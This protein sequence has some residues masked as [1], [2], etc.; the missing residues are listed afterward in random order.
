MSPLR[1]RILAA[2]LR[3]FDVLVLSGAFLLSLWVSSARETGMPVGE[4]LSVR[5]RAGNFILLAAL[6]WL[7]H[8]LFTAFGLY[9]SRRLASRTGEVRDVVG[10]TFCAALVLASFG[11]VFHIELVTRNFLAVFWA[12]GV[13]V[14]IAGRLAMRLLL[15]RL[16]LGGHNLRH[17]VVVG[18]NDRALEFA[19]RLEL[20][21]TLGY[22]IVG[23]VDHRW[24][25]AEATRDAKW[26]LLGKFEDFPDVLSRRV[27]DEVVL[28]LPVKSFYQEASR[29]A[30]LCE[31]Q[32]IVVRV[33]PDL[34]DVKFRR[35]T[36]AQG[37]QDLAISLNAVPINT[38][39]QA[40]KRVL[41][42]VIAGVLLII[43]APLFLIIA[44]MIVTDSPG[45]VFF[46][47]MRRG[48]N[49]RPFQMIKFRSMRADAEQRLAELTPFN[50]AGGP[51]F[52]LKQDPRITRVGGFL[53]RT[54]LD[55][56]PQMVNILRG[57]MS[58]VGPRPLF[59]WEFDRIQGEWIKRRCAVKPGLTGLW[60]VSGR[61][62][63]PFETRIKL[64]LEYIDN[65]SLGL[66]L[67]ILAKTIPVVLL[68]RGAL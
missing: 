59:A 64:D 27:V 57:E 65:W 45:P 23:F 19:R 48:L 61:S 60:Q 13:T 16:R 4:L 38:S 68:G 35:G 34:F 5:V 55:E 39:A 30:A 46:L 49:K 31:E 58:L 6:L 18:T 3:A 41:D 22:R 11:A 42:I 56:L 52:K 32:G 67:K 28:C 17:V 24:V 10:A 66:D 54:S 36:T 63:L 40:V 7:W 26:N 33:L 43:T 9:E 25:G 20:E 50:E 47:Q 12:S 29:L 1:R 44:I 37:A 8:A 53:R 21:P 62:Q 14:L 2:A 51:S 15:A